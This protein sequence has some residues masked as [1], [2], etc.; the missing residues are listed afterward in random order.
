MGRIHPAV[1]RYGR[2]GTNVKREWTRAFLVVPKH[3]AEAPAYV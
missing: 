1:I 2:F 3:I